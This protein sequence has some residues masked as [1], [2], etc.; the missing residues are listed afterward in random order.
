MAEEGSGTGQIG[1]V[2]RHLARVDRIT[3]EAALLRA[4][5][6][7]VP[8]SALDQA[9][10][11]ASS[12]RARSLRHPVDEIGGSLGIRLHRKTQSGPLAGVGIPRQ[13]LDH[14]QGKVQPVG[15]FRID[16]ELYP[17][18][19]RAARERTRLGY[20]ALHD[21]LP[22]QQ[23]IARLERRQLDRDARSLVWAAP[24]CAG[25]DDVD[26]MLVGFQ[27]PLC[28]EQRPS[29]LAQHV[30]GAQSEFRFAGAARQGFLDAAP[31]DEFS[32]DDPH[33]TAH[34]EPHQGL[35]CLARQFAD[36]SRGIGL[37]RRIE[38]ED[39]AGQHESPRRCVD[40]QGF[41]PAR[42]RRPVTGR[43]L[44]GDEPIGGGVVRNSQQRFCDAHEGD[45]LLIGKP[46]FLQ[47][48]IEE[49]PLVAPRARAFDQRHGQGDCAVSCAAGQFHPT[50]Q[51]VDR[52][53]FLPQAV[54]AQRRA[55]QVGRGF[56]GRFVQIGGHD[57]LP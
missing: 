19:G 41:G 52:Q 36:P 25:T 39:A 37:D 20:Q 53:I 48:C 22:L 13:R 14:I 1:H 42:M 33:C 4:L 55:Q 18:R 30:E 43:E 47:E 16:R 28:I 57:G 24:R 21:A 40:E 49:R 45:T 35:A 5:D 10:R 38:F 3:L 17:A 7:A 6:L 9:N 12:A 44:L 29:A 34:G 50:Q 8:I 26:R 27:V 11:H 15:F 32:A 51:T 56:D 46:E 23:R 31:D 2:R 54:F